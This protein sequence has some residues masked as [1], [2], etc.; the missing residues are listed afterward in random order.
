[1]NRIANIIYEDSSISVE[2]LESQYYGDIL[3]LFDFINK[4]IKRVSERK[5]FY[6]KK[7]KIHDEQVAISDYIFEKIGSEKYIDTF[8]S[9]TEIENLS[10]IKKEI[11]R[12]KELQTKIPQELKDLEW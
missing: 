1:M 9:D 4:A 12:I 6:I 2:D 11:E 8:F 7:K 3:L 5:D 10:V